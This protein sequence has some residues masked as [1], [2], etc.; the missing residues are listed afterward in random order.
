MYYVI[1]KAI[2]YIIEKKIAETKIIATLP[3]K[4]LHD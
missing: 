2:G 4:E 1:F 3:H